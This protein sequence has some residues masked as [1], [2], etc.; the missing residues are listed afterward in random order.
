MKLNWTLPNLIREITYLFFIIFDR[1]K[2]PPPLSQSNLL[3]IQNLVYVTAV[4][5]CLYF[6]SIYTLT[7][8]LVCVDL[9]E[10]PT[11][12]LE[13]LEE[14][15]FIEPHWSLSINDNTLNSRYIFFIILYSE[16]CP[17]NNMFNYKLGMT[18]T[19]ICFHFW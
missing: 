8:H 13:Y 16:W 10:N 3:T 11:E 7:L 2:M 5:K 9:Y 18:C 4:L 1:R 14:N 17:W 6:Y 19:I 12:T 15:L